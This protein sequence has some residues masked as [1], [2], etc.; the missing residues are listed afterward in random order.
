MI[1]GKLPEESLTSLSSSD[2]ARR[3]LIAESDAVHA[4]KWTAFSL[5]CLPGQAFS[6]RIALGSPMK[7]NT[8]ADYE[9]SA[10]CTFSGNL[11]IKLG[12]VALKSEF[13]TAAPKEEDRLTI[14]LEADLSPRRVAHPADQGEAHHLRVRA[15]GPAT[16]PDDRRQGSSGTGSRECRVLPRGGGEA[17]GMKPRH[18]APFR[19]PRADSQSACPE[20]MSFQQDQKRKLPNPT[21][22]LG[23]GAMKSK[24]LFLL[25]LPSLALTHPDHDTKPGADIEKPVLTGNGAWQLKRCPHWGELPDGKN[26]GPTHGGVVIDPKTGLIYVST[27]APHGILVYQPD[28]KLKE[29]IAPECQGFHAMAVREE[30]GKTVLYGAQLSGPKPLRGLQDRYRPG[31][32][33]LEISQAT[34]GEVK[35]GWK[36]LTAVTV[37]PDGAIFCSMGYGAQFIHKFDAAGKL[38]KSFGGKGNGD[39]QTSCSHG[40]ALDTRFG[41]PVCP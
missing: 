39:G 27:D 30:E 7:R 38:I 5:H 32:V 8:D 9:A 22:P 34:A 18:C 29:S 13:R 23:W 11:E 6:S 15:P 3:A 10:S 12:T 2:A 16:I 14:S 24:A 28:G 4:Y 17:V 37:A 36:G 25:L 19:K 41:A 21:I 33:L 26:I 1:I 40:M 31:K 20:N 35:G